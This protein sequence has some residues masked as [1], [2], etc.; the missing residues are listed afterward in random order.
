VATISPVGI[1]EAIEKSDA[2]LIQIV[3]NAYEGIGETG[4]TKLSDFV[5]E[6]EMY[7]P[8][9]IDKVVF[10][11][12]ILNSTAQEK[13]KERKWIPIEFDMG[14]KEQD[15]IVSYNF[16]KEEGGLDPNK[17]GKILKEILV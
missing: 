1:K 8:R 7:L 4:P 9:Q 12:T 17:L 11:K 14:E 16:E 2:K 13:Y 15:R 3:G 6:L 10:N 5:G